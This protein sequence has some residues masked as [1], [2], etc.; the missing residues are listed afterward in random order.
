M[1]DA[2]VWDVSLVQG[3]F[4]VATVPFVI[5]NVTPGFYLRG[6]VPGLAGVTTRTA[7]R[8]CSFAVGWRRATH[9][10]GENLST[11]PPHPTP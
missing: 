11:A 7:G 2:K 3:P 5:V 1:H 8:I 9:R 6:G 4:S 10:D